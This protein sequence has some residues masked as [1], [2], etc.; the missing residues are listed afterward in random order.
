[1]VCLRSWARRSRAELECLFS[2]G[3]DRV[4]GHNGFRTGDSR[5]LEHELADAPRADHDDRSVWLHAR[6]GQHRAD[7]GERGAAEQRR[8]LEW[9]VLAERQGVPLGN[10]HTLGQRT[11][12]RAAVHGL[13]VER[14]PCSSVHQSPGA[15]RSVQRD[16]R[17][18][19][20]T[21]TVCALAA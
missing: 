7:A 8:L 6:R 17:G 9:H 20:A 16:A 10:D 19:P 11:G 13:A 5:T 14:H 15:D 4:D 12:G 2:P 1:M 18:G 21:R 3:L